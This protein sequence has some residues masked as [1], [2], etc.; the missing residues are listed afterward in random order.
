MAAPGVRP[1][2]SARSL[3]GTGPYRTMD[4]MEST[5]LGALAATASAAAAVAD[6]TEADILVVTCLAAADDMI[7]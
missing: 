1:F 6:A 7:Y 3:S 5:D 4:G 2:L